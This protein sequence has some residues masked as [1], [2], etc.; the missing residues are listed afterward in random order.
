MW[1]RCWGSVSLPDRRVAG[2]CRLERPVGRTLTGRRLIYFIGGCSCLNRI[3]GAHRCVGT[4]PWVWPICVGQGSVPLQPVA[5]RCPRPCSGGGPTFTPAGGPGRPCCWNIAE[6]AGVFAHRQ[7]L[8]CSLMLGG[9]LA[10]MPPDRSLGQP[11]GRRHRPMRGWRSV[12][13]E[14]AAHPGLP[15][16]GCSWAAAVPLVA[17]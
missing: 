5:S 15:T 8:C 9:T 13:R 2:C 4:V 17:G 10:A 7:S 12:F 14:L 16:V 3:P 1:W 6:A 11:G